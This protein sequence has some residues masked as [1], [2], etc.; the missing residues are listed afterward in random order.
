MTSGAVGTSPAEA[1]FAEQVAQ[2]VAQSRPANPLLVDSGLAIA[3]WRT[4]G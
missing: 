4:H 1:G 2:D 3:D